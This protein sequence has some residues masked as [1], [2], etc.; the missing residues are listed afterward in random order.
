M[1]T[2]CICINRPGNT[3]SLPIATK[4]NESDWANLRE[5]LSYLEAI[6]RDLPR[7]G[8]DLIS[9]GSQR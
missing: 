3:V 5:E 6:N 8:K 2:A 7:A 4:A 1:A 9:A